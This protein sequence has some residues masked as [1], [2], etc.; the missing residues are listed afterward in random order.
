MPHPDPIPVGGVNPTV[1]GHYYVGSVWGPKKATVDAYQIST[2]LRVPD[3]VGATAAGGQA[4]FYYV[5]MSAFDNNGSYDQIGLSDDYGVWGMTY[6]YT[7][8]TAGTG[9]TGTLAYVY[10][11]DTFNLNPGQW[12]TFG[13]IFY[14]NYPGDMSF[15][16]FQG[17]ALV[18]QLTVYTG[19]TA[20]VLQNNNCGYYGTTDYEEVYDTQQGVPDV[21]MHFV[22]GVH[23]GT[24]LRCRSLPIRSTPGSSFTVP[25]LN[26]AG[27]VV[28]GNQETS[29]GFYGTSTD[30]ILTSVNAASVTMDLSFSAIGSP[31]SCPSLPPG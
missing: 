13:M 28:I 8:D 2:Q 18:Y 30:T 6:S 1:S 23:D 4:E 26:S 5:I 11:P 21:D 31:G 24:E 25:V 12:Y 16:V 17:S 14:T 22:G 3:Q 9:C 27:A 15:Y 7:Y 10:N 29:I 19:G 20:F